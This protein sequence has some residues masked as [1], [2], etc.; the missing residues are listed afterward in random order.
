MAKLPYLRSC[1]LLLLFLVVW[2]ADVRAQMMMAGPLPIDAPACAVTPTESATI[3]PASYDDFDQKTDGAASWRAIMNRGCYATSASLIV[4]YLDHNRSVLTEEQVRTLNFHA[5]QTFALGGRDNDAAPFFERSRGGASR[6]WNEYVNA[7]L[8]FVRHDR[9]K[10][11]GARVVYDSVAPQSPRRRL[12]SAMALCFAKPY[13]EAAMCTSPPA[14]QPKAIQYYNPQWSPDGR[15]LLFESTREGKF[16]VYTVVLDGSGLSKLTSS[17]YNNE[18]PNWSHDGR[19]IVFSSDR[20][21][22]FL[23]LYLMNRNGSQQQRLTNFHGGGYY[24][25]SFSPDHKWIV[26]Q[27]REDNHLIS[28]KIHVVR[29]DGTGYRQLTDSTTISEGPHWSADG[30]R[31]FF[32]QYPAPKRLW[33][34]MTR[35]AV[36]GMRKTQDIVSIR[37]DGSGFT[38][39]TTNDVKDCCAA[40]TAD[41]KTLWFLSARDSAD[42]IYEMNLDGSNVRRIGDATPALRGLRSPDGRFAAYEKNEGAVSGI[43]VVEIAT[44]Q[45]RLVIGSPRPTPA[46]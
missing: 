37:P 21:G 10:F 29:V 39:L 18:Q 26:F 14:T 38:R 12:L 40:V 5:A 9:A 22:G 44:G 35:D 41:G 45:E 3:L 2:P 43:Y 15:T 36:Q 4:R 16:A 46:K 11:D 20:D 24:R 32:T 1:S 6:E 33:S 23:N 34:E 30:R 17:D 7:S 19:R 8:E 31:I 25:S 13:A 28:D 42:A 27:G